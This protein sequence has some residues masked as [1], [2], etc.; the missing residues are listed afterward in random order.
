MEPPKPVALVYIVPVEYEGVEGPCEDG[1]GLGTFAILSDEEVRDEDSEDLDC[2]R[3]MEHKQQK[4]RDYTKEITA[5]DGVSRRKEQPLSY[6]DSTELFEHYTGVVVDLRLWLKSF[7][8]LYVLSQLRLNSEYPNLTK[9]IPSFASSFS[10]ILT[11]I[12]RLSQARK[13]YIG[14]PTSKAL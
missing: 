12:R 5:N 6:D 2:A 10:N 11:Q 4:N 7:W 3:P 13:K 9:A 14:Q 1:G 8:R